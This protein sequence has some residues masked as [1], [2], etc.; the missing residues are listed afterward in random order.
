MTFSKQINTAL[1][2]I[3]GYRLTHE[4]PEQQQNRIERDAARAALDS[5]RVGF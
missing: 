2:S 5:V 3:T 4:T 1:R